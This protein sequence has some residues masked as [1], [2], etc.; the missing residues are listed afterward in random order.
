MSGW[1]PWQLAITLCLAGMVLTGWGLFGDRSRG[2]RRC[3]NCWY[4]MRKT[5]SLTCSECGNTVTGEGKLQQTRRRWRWVATG[6]AVILVGY[7]LPTTSRIRQSGWLGAVPTTILIPISDWTEE[8]LDPVAV[9][10]ENRVLYEPMWRWQRS[11]AIR[12]EVARLHEHSSHAGVLLLRL[13]QASPGDAALTAALVDAIESTD[14]VV[15]IAASIALSHGL[16]DSSLAVEVFVPL[17]QD[18]SQ[19]TRFAAAFGLREL[20]REVKDALPALVEAL[21]DQDDNVRLM[22]A[23]AIC[24]VA[25][26]PQPVLEVLIEFLEHGNQVFRNAA[27]EG[28]RDLGSKSAPATAALIVAAND[29]FI[30][31]RLKAIETLGLIGP[32]ASEAIP[33][34]KDIAAS[35][36]DTVAHTAQLA[37]ESI[38]SP[39]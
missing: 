1:W 15:R 30:W 23:R 7:L 21:D 22:V 19:S 17:L 3:P 32:E 28:L 16:R 6:L 39:P 33:V 11:W 37:L 29:P 24:K 9:H 34:L 25:D 27:A 4:D 5:D 2:R 14:P 20:G 26:D 38:D 12:R 10:L 36:D 18:E 35:E 31:V 13:A 8:L